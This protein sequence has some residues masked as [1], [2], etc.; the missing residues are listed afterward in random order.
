MHEVEEALHEVD[1]VWAAL[2]EVEAELVLAVWAA[3]HEAAWEALP[4][5][6]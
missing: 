6:V 4:E 1:A 5:A 2:H 3:W